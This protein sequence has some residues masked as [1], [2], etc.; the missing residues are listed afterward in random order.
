[1]TP[2]TQLK[3]RVCQFV[4]ESCS[5]RDAS[6]SYDHSQRVFNLSLE[7]FNHIPSSS[8]SSSQS[9]VLNLI[10]LVALLHDVADHKYDDT[11]SQRQ[12]LQSFLA[13]L[14]VSVDLIIAI[15]DSISYSNE[16]K[17][18]SKGINVRRLLRDNYGSDVLLVRDI[19]SDAD[20]IDALGVTGLDRCIEFTRV[21]SPNATER[22][23]AEHVE[24]HA[25]NKLISLK[26]WTRTVYGRVLAEKATL[27]FN[28]ALNEYLGGF[29]SN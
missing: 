27:E 21:M 11:I 2:C 4:Q 16:K 23:V 5:N 18:L 8:F 10:T 17:Q 13:S 26:D 3:H 29:K 20:K 22:E 1:M 24:K 9:E 19:V 25:N 15:I 14:N 12:L 28:N 7:I 6:H